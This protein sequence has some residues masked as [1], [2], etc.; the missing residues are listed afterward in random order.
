MKMSPQSLTLFCLL[1]QAI[2]VW[3]GTNEEGLAFL[4]ANKEK[5]GVI[6]LPSGLQYKVLK[7][8]SG[9]MHPKVDTPCFCH[10]T[11]KLISGEVFDSSEERGQPTTFAPN[12]VIK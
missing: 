9:M 3:A 11:G 7:K 1:L 5:E 6:E 2:S 12:Q 4:K 8:G 10:Y